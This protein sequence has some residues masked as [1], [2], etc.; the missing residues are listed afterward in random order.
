[1][2][3][4]M[5]RAEFAVSWADIDAFERVGPALESKSIEEAARDVALTEDLNPE[6]VCVIA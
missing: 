1:M 3:D 2:P 5:L 4:V 6:A